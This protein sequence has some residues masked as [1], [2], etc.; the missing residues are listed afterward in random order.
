MRRSLRTR[1]FGG[2]KLTFLYVPD[3]ASVR[4]FMVP[5]FLF[6]ALAGVA[7]MGL[8]LIAFFGSR[9]LSAAA[10][11]RQLLA[12][13]GENVQLRQSLRDMQNLIQNQGRDAG[14]YRRPSEAA[15]GCH[16]TADPEVL[17][18]GVGPLRG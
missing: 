15:H 8:G 17:E 11:G 2:K 12:T 1:L 13:Q 18:A 4:Q 6:Y 10:E 16:S 5:K 3:N 7:F 14:E 9:Y